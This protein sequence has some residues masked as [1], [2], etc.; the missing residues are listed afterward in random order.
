MSS[1]KVKANLLAA[2]LFMTSV[3]GT[4]A[5]FGCVPLL[6]RLT[7]STPVAAPSQLQAFPK[8][9]ERPNSSKSSK[10]TDTTS[11]SYRG[12]QARALFNSWQVKQQQA[13]PVRSAQ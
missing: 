4:F 6:A 2:S 11:L 13:S 3:G 12:K 1:Q 7:S 8:V 9:S 5:I 10:S